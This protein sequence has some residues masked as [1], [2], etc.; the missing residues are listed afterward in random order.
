MFLQIIIG[1]LLYILGNQNSPLQIRLNKQ[2]VLAVREI[3][4]AKRHEN[5][6]VNTVFKN[7]I[8]L[9]LYYMEGKVKDKDSINWE[10]IKEPFSYSFVLDPNKTFAFQED[11]LPEYEGKIAKTTNAHFNFQEGFKSDG[12]LYGD[13]VCHLA[14]LIYWVAKDAGLDT[15]APA[16]HNFRE[17]PEIPQEYGV[18]IYSMPGQKSTNAHQNL[19]VTNNR[20]NPIIFNFEYNGEILK[21]VMKEDVKGI[22]SYAL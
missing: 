16:N 4:L 2:S 10:E 13:G 18:S 12:Y 7:N 20:D 14:S 5:S 17:I 15:L 19:Y 3:S 11:A 8:L 9:N 6:S 22:I 21:L 1:S